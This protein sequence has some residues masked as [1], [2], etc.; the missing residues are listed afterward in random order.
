MKNQIKLSLWIACALLS[1][2]ALPT[3]TSCS[4]EDGNVEYY[5]DEPKQF[6]GV[7]S[8]INYNSKEHCY[9]VTNSYGILYQGNSW[10]CGTQPTQIMRIRNCAYPIDRYKNKTCLLSGTYRR[11][12]FV[13]PT[14]QYPMGIVYYDVDIKTISECHSGWNCG[15]TE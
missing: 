15:T 3:L 4:D 13:N 14:E 7:E 2:L 11:I 10:V 9:L 12:K 8:E 1:F 5:N 6:V